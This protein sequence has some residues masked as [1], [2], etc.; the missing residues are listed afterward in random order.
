MVGLRAEW[1]GRLS[2][3]IDARIGGDAMVEPFEITVPGGSPASGLSTPSFGMSNAGFDQT[4]VS[5]SVYGELVWRPSSRLEVRPGARV[6]LFTSSYP[7]G[8]P[9]PGIGGPGGATVAAVTVD[10]RLAARWQVTSAVAWTTDL[11][12]V[13]QPSNLP[14]PSPGVQFSQLS[15]GVQAGYQLAE[16]AEV[17][18]PGD[19]TAT[20]DVFVQN[21]TGL[22]DLYESCPPGQSTCSFSGR[23]IGM[24]LLVRRALTQ[25]FTG[26]LSYTVSRTERDSFYGGSWLRR[27]SEFDRTHV[28]NLILAADLGKRWRAGARLVAYS[29]LPYSTTIQN[30][31]PDAR[32]PPF[33]RLDLRVE[34]R[35]NALGGTMALVFEWLN[36]LLSKETFGTNCTS[37][38]GAGGFSFHCQPTEVGPITF[39]SVGLDA[40]W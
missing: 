3:K 10:P 25:R 15:R 40:A 39:P 33:F 14:L 34:K 6:D 37:D 19:F 4:D 11:G 22:A 2:E 13:H 20:G 23:A 35:W 7:A 18:L 36:A 9:P 32:E 21:Y 24:E 29:G 17:A 8:R 12:I 5:S 27:L 16:G 30:G 38:Y 31:P 26:W 1:S 28:A